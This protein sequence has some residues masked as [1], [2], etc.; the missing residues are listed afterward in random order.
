M[1][2]RSYTRRSVEERYLKE[3][4]KLD[5]KEAYIERLSDK[6]GKQRERVSKLQNRLVPPPTPT[7]AS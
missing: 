4:K 6:L 3:K 2:P 5:I 7:A 1:S